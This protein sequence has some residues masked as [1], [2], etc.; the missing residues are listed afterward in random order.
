MEDFKSTELGVWTVRS[1]Q[2]TNGE[3]RCQSPSPSSPDERGAVSPYWCVHVESPLG[4]PWPQGRNYPACVCG[5][6]GAG[7]AQWAGA[8]RRSLGAV[9]GRIR[10]LL[11]GWRHPLQNWDWM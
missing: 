8:T 6:P 11:E 2:R 1:T 10:K 7:R 3:L 9:E 5:P 4:S